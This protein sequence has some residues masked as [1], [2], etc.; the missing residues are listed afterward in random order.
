MCINISHCAYGVYRVY[1]ELYTPPEAMRIAFEFA[2]GAKPDR[3]FCRGTL[4]ERL[5]SEPPER[6]R[7]PSIAE[8]WLSFPCL[9]R[10]Q[11]LS[12][13]LFLLRLVLLF[14]FLLFIA[15]APDLVR[16]SA[17]A[18]ANPHRFN[19]AASSVD[20]KN[21]SE[22][23]ARSSARSR[24]AARLPRPMIRRTTGSITQQLPS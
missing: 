6:N 2:N 24:R 4:P 18:S 11:A 1:T 10:R 17:E 23:S 19:V 7:F 21:R 20:S 8:L 16:T 14:L 15:V 12:S 3:L 22:D 13:W 9:S 5:H